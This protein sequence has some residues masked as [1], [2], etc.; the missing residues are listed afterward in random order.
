MDQDEKDIRKWFDD[1][2]TSTEEGDLELAKSLIADDAIFLVP[3]AGQMDKQSFAEAATASDPNTEFL[4]D[5]KVQEVRVFGDHAWLLST[6]SLEM[7]DKQSSSR[8][9]MKGDG[10]SILERRRDGWVVVRDANTMI[11]VPSE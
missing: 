10:I 8:T 7:T 3:G 11:E 5:G 2:M 4:L 9:L 6:I 1:W